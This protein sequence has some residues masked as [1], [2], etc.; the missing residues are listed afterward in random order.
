MKELYEKYRIK[1]KILK[2]MIEELRE[3]ML[4]KSAKVKRCEQ[5]IE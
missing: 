1:R 5:R 2:T 4:A 3:R